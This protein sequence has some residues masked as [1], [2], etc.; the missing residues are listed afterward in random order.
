MTKTKIDESRS[1]LVNTARD[2]IERYIFDRVLR[3]D[4][5]LIE[6]EL[7][8]KLGLSRTPLR[9][10]LRQ[11]EVKGLITKLPTGGYVVTYYTA[12]DVINIFE[13]REALETLAM[14]LAC[15]RA[16]REQ[17]DRAGGMLQPIR[18]DYYRAQD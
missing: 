10:A 14:R 9:E 17:L 15:D 4:Q 3:P 2:A 7:S 1:N 8:E 12:E 5:R 18:Q 11:L 6:S 13:I 16:T